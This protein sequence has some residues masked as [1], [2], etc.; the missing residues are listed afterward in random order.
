MWRTILRALAI[1]AFTLLI[2]VVAGWFLPDP[3]G[4]AVESHGAASSEM[5]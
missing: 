2:S 3:D 5:R 4:G 1:G